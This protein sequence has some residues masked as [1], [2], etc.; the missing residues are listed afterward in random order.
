MDSIDAGNSWKM[1]RSYRYIE[2]LLWCCVFIIGPLFKSETSWLSAPS[3]FGG[4]HFLAFLFLLWL[5]FLYL[6]IYFLFFYFYFFIFFLPFFQSGDVR[7]CWAYLFSFICFSM[8][9]Y[10]IFLLVFVCFYVFYR[11]RWCSLEFFLS[12]RK[13]WF[14]TCVR[15]RAR[16]VPP[17]S[18]AFVFFRFRGN[19]LM[20]LIGP[21]TLNNLSKSLTYLSSSYLI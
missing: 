10:L 5:L 7:R 16:S 1:D 2:S 6:F 12:P 9:I 8:F 20:S 3:S 11:C 15:L 14:T 19:L 17:F 21:E 18:S 4:F 13:F